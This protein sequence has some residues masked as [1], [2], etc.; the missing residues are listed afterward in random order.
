MSLALGYEYKKTAVETSTPEKLLLM[1]YEG[2]ISFLK[3][4]IAAAE[5][6]DYPAV[7]ERLQRVQAI[8]G[9]LMATLNPNYEVSRQLMTLYDYF[10]RRLI[11]ANVKK[12]Q[13]IMEE[14]LGML[15]ELK[16]VWEEAARK[17]RSERGREGVAAPRPA[18]GLNIQW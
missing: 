13:A 2:A 3:E 6:K 14:V 10:L 17:A 16:G 9:E 18:G 4:A 8:V 15:S 12:D 5:G 7:N 11:E 1:L